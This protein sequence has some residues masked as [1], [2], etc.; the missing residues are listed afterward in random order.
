VPAPDEAALK[1]GE[2]LV[3]RRRV[4]VGTATRPVVLGEVQ[5]QGK[6]PMPADAWA[7]GV[8]PADG[9]TMDTDEETT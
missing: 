3:E 6:R 7:R 4:L 9:E 1:P 5:P 8:R 2:L